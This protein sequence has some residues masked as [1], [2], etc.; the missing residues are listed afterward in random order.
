MAANKFNVEI[1]EDG[2]ISVDSDDFDP[3]VHK[4]ADEFVK[5]LSELMGGEVVV[6][7][8]RTHAKHHHHHHGH[9]HTHHTH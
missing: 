6:K 9:G 8:K 1:L 4:S 5:Y 7:E 2:T 3:Q